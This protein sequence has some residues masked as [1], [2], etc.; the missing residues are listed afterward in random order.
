MSSSISRL[1]DSA[2]RLISSH[3]A[4]VTSSLLVKELLDNAIDAKATLVEILVSSDTISRVEVRDN[5]VGIHPNDFDALGRCGHTSKLRNIEELGNLAG[6]SL[7]FR[8]EALASANSMADVTITTKVS[9]EPVATVCQLIPNEGGVLIQNPTSAPVGTTVSVT[10]LFSRQPV[11]E[12]LAVKE[13]RKTLDSIQELLK[14]YVM[15]RPQLKIL[16]KVLQ[17][18]TKTWSYS[19]K[20]NST[21]IEAALQLFGVEVTSNC[22]LKTLQTGHASTKGDS[23][24]RETPRPTTDNFLL[25]VFLAN[26]DTNLRK[27]PKHHYFSVDGRPINAGRG[28]AKRLLKIYLDHLKRS[29]LVKDISDCFIRLNICCPPGSYDVNIEPSKDDVLFSDEHVVLD[30]F[31]RLCEEVYKPASVA[32]QGT[33]AKANARVNGAPTIN[34]SGQG[35]LH[36]VHGSQV[37]PDSPDSD[38]TVRSST[39]ISSQISHH[40]TNRSLNQASITEKSIV[41]QELS[42]TQTSNLIPFTPINTGNVPAC[43]QSKGPSGEESKPHLAQSQWKV[44]MSVDLNERPE[45]SHQKRPPVIRNVLPSQESEKSKERSTSDRLDPWEIA[46]LNSSIEASPDGAL[47]YTLEHHP[48]TPEPPVLR[49]IMAPPG[50][51]DVPRSQRNMERTNTPYP[52]WPMVPGGPYRSPMASP[53]NVKPISSGVPFDRS[54][55]TRRRRGE[56][57]PWTPPSPL[58]KTRR[59]DMSQIEPT[60]LACADGFKQTQISFSGSRPSRRRGEPRGKNAQAQVGEPETNSNLNTQDMFWKA[61]KNL[62]YQ[63]SQTEDQQGIE[64]VQDA[65]PQRHQESSRQRQP[66]SLLQTNTFRNSEAPQ[67]DQELIATTLPTGDPRAY[68][69]RRQKSMAAKEGSSKPQKLRRQKSSL[70]PLENIPPECHTHVLS[71]AI[72]I[73]SSALNEL[74][75]WVRKYDE[76]VIYGT[77]VDGLEMG[78]SD[79]GAVESRLNKLLAKQKENIGNEDTGNNPITIDLQAKLKGKNVS[80]EP[81]S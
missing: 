7:G 29:T 12:Q 26:P 1:P 56:N 67:E 42:N 30:A 43:S 55:T 18:P 60:H 65:G 32:H 27:V 11:R 15:A 21:V 47:R 5:G 77:L 61:A 9:T 38:K 49:H 72:S 73:G 28:V 36:R 8:G 16:L 44:N 46:K 76:Y 2:T 35:Q 51:L 79:G 17:T 4:I 19:P 34:S 48:M 70:M 71:L 74:V 6:K 62:H 33:L 75:R 39:Q 59:I 64:V 37:R 31:R 22:L 58:E 25:E 53:S 50:D 68:L 81:T 69:L 52:R 3:L 13:A 54:Q 40:D 57:L 23:P 45:R 78:L 80:D 41:G 10:N 66:F 20:R 63:I 14:S 24:A